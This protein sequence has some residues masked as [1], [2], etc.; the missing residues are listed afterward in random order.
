MAVGVDPGGDHHHGVHDP[1]ALPDLHRR[2]RTNH[3][4]RLAV[5][6]PPDGRFKQVWTRTEDNKVFELCCIPFFPYSLAFGDPIK[7]ADDGTFLIV[8]KSGHQTIRA[9]IHDAKY[10]HER[11]AEFHALIAG[12]GV[13]WE[14]LGH[15][16]TY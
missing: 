1:P 5:E 16:S 2:A 6:N 8:E 11:H 14:T 15:A 9:V 12:T 13:R 4:H 10:T 7:I 3:I